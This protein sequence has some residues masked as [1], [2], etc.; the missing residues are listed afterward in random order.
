ML[1]LPQ[2]AGGRYLNRENLEG[3]LDKLASEG[4]TAGAL[5]AAV[6]DRDALSRAP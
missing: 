1:R 3:L 5:P 2:R 6:I 4:I